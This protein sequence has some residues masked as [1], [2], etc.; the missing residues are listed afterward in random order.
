MTFLLNGRSFLV[1]YQGD[2]VDLDDLQK[3]DFW[4]EVLEYSWAIERG[5]RGH[6]HLFIVTKEK[7]RE[8]DATVLKYND[9]MPNIEGGTSRGRSA[10]RTWDRGHF[11]VYCPFK[12]SHVMSST[13]YMPMVKYAVDSSWVMTMWRQGKID[14]PVRCAATYR[15]LTPAMEGQVK[16]VNKRNIDYMR[17]NVLDGRTKKLT[18]N[19]VLFKKIPE[20]EM[21]METFESVQHRYK[22]LWLHGPS[23]N[24]KT[25]FAV[26]LKKMTHLHSAGVDWT[27]YDAGQ[28]DAIVFDDIFDMET[29]INMHKPIFQSARK[30]AVNTSKTNC[31]SQ[32]IDTAGKM[33]IV[34]NN[35]APTTSWVLANTIV[36]E[37]DEP[38]FIKYHA[39]ANYG[40]YDEE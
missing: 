4:Q 33:I 40:E 19:M 31:F 12:T 27:T 15:V 28:H 30:T 5:A 20:V 36:V 13:N 37:V 22:F 21:W 7:Q 2:E 34:C 11:Y 24:G 10:R 8:V 17:E 32:L 25:M 39:L 23:G 18:S 1:T 6:T 14:D 16:L 26:N 35:D 38:L 9:K 3:L 29:Y